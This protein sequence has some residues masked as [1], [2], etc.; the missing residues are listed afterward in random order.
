[1]PCIEFVPIL[2][3]ML[4]IVRELFPYH[5]GQERTPTYNVEVPML[6]KKGV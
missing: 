4:M 5:K 1:M 3:I 2:K 6:L